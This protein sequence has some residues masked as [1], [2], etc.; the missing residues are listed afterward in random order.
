MTV[1]PVIPDCI[2]IIC[3]GSSFQS[4]Y[5]SFFFRPTLYVREAAHHPHRHNGNLDQGIFFFFFIPLEPRVE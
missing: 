3:T 4:P 1:I 2:T 5:W